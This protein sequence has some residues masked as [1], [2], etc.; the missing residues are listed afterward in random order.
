MSAV[1]FFDSNLFIYLIDGANPAKQAIAERLIARALA[2]N[3]ACISFQVVQE[4]LHVLTRKFAHCVP[5]EVA[6]AILNHT[7]LPFWHVQPSAA[8]Y[9]RA[10]ELQA[11]Y[12]Y[13]FYDSLILAAALESGCTRLLSED[14]QDG[15]RIEG[16]T[17]ENP[18]KD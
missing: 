17:I 14:F 13:S 2:D 8:L 16:L 11:R 12:Q 9:T 18:F 10:L 4:T 3:R 6:T 5:P 1:D 7:L 15:Q